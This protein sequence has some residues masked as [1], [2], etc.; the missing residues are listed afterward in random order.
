MACV[1]YLYL[2]YHTAVHKMTMVESLPLALLGYEFV[3]TNTQHLDCSHN[4]LIPLPE[5]FA[6]PAENRCLDTSSES[7]R[8]IFLP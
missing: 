2:S 8:H 4:A 1:Y 5:K 3:D 6:R 7:Q